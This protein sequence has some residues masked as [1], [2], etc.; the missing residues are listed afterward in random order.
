MYF[1]QVP[2]WLIVG[3]IIPTGTDYNHCKVYS[4]SIFSVFDKQINGHNWLKID[5]QI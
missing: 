1:E 5:P 3:L 2:D 4:R